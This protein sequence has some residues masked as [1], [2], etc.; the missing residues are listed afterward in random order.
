[1]IILLLSTS[2]GTVLLMCCL[3]W[4]SDCS[5]GEDTMPYQTTLGIL[6][7]REKSFLL[8]HYKK[9]VIC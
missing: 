5:N 8:E 9:D 4:Y 7:S 1:V 3:V 6:L 2:E